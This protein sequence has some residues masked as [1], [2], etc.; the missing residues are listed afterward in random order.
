MATVRKVQTYHERKFFSLE[1]K[2]LVETLEETLNSP[3]GWKY[4]D[5]Y[6]FLDTYVG[7][8]IPDFVKG[9]NGFRETVLLDNP[10]VAYFLYLL[11]LLTHTHQ[12]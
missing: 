5:T 3:C 1:N 6:T 2:Y 9:V 4:A 12:I 11:K 10:V 7:I 8:L